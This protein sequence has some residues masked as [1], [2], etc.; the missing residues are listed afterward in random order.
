[1]GPAVITMA[2]SDT[3]LSQQVQPSWVTYEI[4]YYTYDRTTNTFGKILPSQTQNLP[5]NENWS[6]VT[7]TVN[8]GSPTSFAKVLGID[9][10]NVSASATGVHRP[11][12]VCIVVDFSGSMSFDSLL[13][14]SYSGSRTQ[15]NNPETVRPQF[16][17]YS[18]STWNPVATT[19]YV[20]S[21][22]EVLGLANIT[23][24][25]NAGTAL[26]NDY[27]QNAFGASP[28]AAFTP[29]SASYATTPG[30]DIPL[31]KTQNN[32]TQPYATSVADI[33][34]STTFNTQW[35]TLGYDDGNLARGQ[36]YLGY[37]MGP[38]HW[39]KTFWIWP[40]DPRAT[41]DWRRKFFMKADTMVSGIGL[42]VDDNSRLWTTGTGATVKAPLATGS[43][44]TGYY[45]NYAAILRWLTTTGPNP[46]PNQLR[47]GRVW[48]YT[49]IPD[50]SNPAND[51]ALNLR[52]Y[53]ATP[54]DLN[55]R[56]WKDFIDFV[57]GFDQNGTTYGNVTA[58]IGYGP[59]YTW[60]TKT[61]SA[62]PVTPDLRYMNYS[63]NPPRP[64]TG[65]WFGPMNM[66]D[67]IDNYNQG[68]RWM[69]GT[70][71]QASSWGCKI[72]IRAGLIDIQNN[73]PND[74]VCLSYFNTPAYSATDT[75]G[76]FNRIREPLGHRYPRMI[77]LLFFPMTTVDN[78]G[79]EINCYD[80]VKM[81]E[82]PHA[83][84]STTP[85]MSFMQAYNQF[86]TNT[87]LQTYNTN[88]GAPVG[89]A[90]GLGRK[91]AQKVVIFETDG[92]ANNGANAAFQNNGP[93]LSYYKIRVGPTTEWPANN[94]GTFSGVDTQLYD[95]AQHIC[96]QDTAGV[97]GYSTPKKPALIHSIAYGS[98]FDPAVSAGASA[99]RSSAL[100]IL[101]QCQYIGSTQTSPST[102]LPSYKII[103]GTAQQ[104]IDLMQQCFKNIMESSV[105]VTLIE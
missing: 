59:N 63:D 7:T 66:M 100:T 10:F 39:G 14:S 88:A 34:G 73:H 64:Q 22:G 78:P 21:D 18:A 24:D 47:A 12:D 74:Y 58:N 70:A 25:T 48:Y 90:G 87:A 101:Q 38:S 13:G 44:T 42:G 61:I 62:K 6:L 105:S 104:R 65:Y 46:F 89:D 15:S 85:S 86:S 98:L 92:V 72:G 81:L 23:V 95:I 80:T 43:S 32:P 76:K 17:H 2:T 83:D 4:G 11:R 50:V 3:I 16:G 79:T 84:G 49:A 102:P 91:G 8:Y 82:I 55:E 94:Y 97:P 77:D 5:T 96:N 57:L 53:N 29:Q 71:H 75:T 9:T 56:F 41:F 20:L 19:P 54:T 67:F 33:Y 68:R 27:Y 26:V 28:I 40:P 99:A 93:Y 31:K 69:P 35:E 36:S 30:G 103:T 1:V 52:M 45:I 51:G 37:T 60:G